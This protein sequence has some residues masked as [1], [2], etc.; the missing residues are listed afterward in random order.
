MHAIL[1]LNDSLFRAARRG[2]DS[3]FLNR[4]SL[5]ARRV[6]FEPTRSRVSWNMDRFCS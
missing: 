2:G 3:A 4:N 5:R 1:F 6:H